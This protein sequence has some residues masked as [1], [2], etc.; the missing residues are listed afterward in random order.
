[1]INTKNI[2]HFILNSLCFFPIPLICTA[3]SS[4]FLNQSSYLFNEQSI[5]T[6]FISQNNQQSHDS[7]ANIRKRSRAKRKEDKPIQ[8]QYESCKN[9]DLSSLTLQEDKISKNTEGQFCSTCSSKK[10]SSFQEIK[11][12]IQ[13]AQVKAFK[14][15]I[16]KR[17]IAQIESKIYQT[18]ML[19]SCATDKKWI[20]Q[21]KI[22]WPLIKALCEKT[23]KELKSSIKTRWPEMRVQLALSAPEDGKKDTLFSHPDAWLDKTPTH[24]VSLFNKLSPLNKKELAKAKSIYK[25]TL[26]KITLEKLSNTEFKERLEKERSLQSSKRVILTN[27]DQ[28]NLRKALSNL[29]QK[30]KE[31]YSNVVEEMPLL[32]FLKTGDPNEMELDEGF[33]KMEEKLEDFLKKAEDPEADMGLLLSFK[34]L[35]EDLLKEDKGYCLIAERAKI[36]AEKDESSVKWDIVA[37]SVVPCVITGPWGAA[38]CLVAGVGLGFME[39]KQ[40]QATKKEALGPNVNEQGI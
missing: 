40:A 20:S 34:P 39:Y 31:N 27:T 28:D 23:N 4:T 38:A 15:K 1:M 2:L 11:E 25:N 30:S 7:A 14:E 6:V 19:H 26:L 21:Q 17:M 10:K 32:V 33:T 12:P 5:N 16:Q 9:E 3:E 8:P 13:A 36:Q 24:T 35:V 18:K 22:D 29:R 37:A